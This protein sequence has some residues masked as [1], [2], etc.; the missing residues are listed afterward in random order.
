MQITVLWVLAMQKLGAEYFSWLDTFFQ[1]FTRHS[2][3]KL[4]SGIL[5]AVHLS[6]QDKQ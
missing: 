2:R 5:N 3:A 1:G 6:P 4:H